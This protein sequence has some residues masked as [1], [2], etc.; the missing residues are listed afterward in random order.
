MITIEEKDTRFYIADSTL[1][2]AGEGLFAKQDFEEGDHLEI[3]G[4]CVTKGSISD[5]C[6]QY[7]EKYKFAAT[8]TRNSNRVIVPMGHAGIVNHS[9]NE[10][11][12]NA[13][14]RKIN[15]RMVYYF[16]KDI[17]QDEEI[18]GFYGKPWQKTLNWAKT[19]SNLVDDDWETFLSHGLYNL[20]I[21]SKEIEVNK[22][23]NAK[24]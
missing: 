15:N 24:N 7:A 2:G 6:T 10:E 14:I 1:D 21:L 17:K 8:G 16:I 9:N 13:E 18:L 3:M 19:S 4:V 22:E 11:D 23:E 12:Q 5:R 20:G